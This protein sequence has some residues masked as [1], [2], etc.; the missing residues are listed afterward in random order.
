[1]KKFFGILFAIVILIL[2]FI[3]SVPK[4]K[5]FASSNLKEDI[6][7]YKAMATMEVGS[8]RLLYSYNENERLPMASTTKIITAIC[9]IENNED[10]DKIIEIPHEAQGVEGSSIYLRAGEHLSLR[11][12]LY[13]LMLQ[14]GNDSAVALA[15]ATS[16]TVD[17]FIE[18]A[19][20]FCERVGATNTHIVTPNGL[21][22]DNHYTTAKDLALISCYAMKNPIFREIVSTKKIEISNEFK[23]DPRVILNKNK[24]LKNLE[25]ATGIKTGYTK[26]AG[27]CLVASQKINDMEVVAVVLNCGPMFEECTSLLQNAHNEYS[28]VKLLDAYNHLGG[29]VAETGKEQ[30]KVNV[31]NKEGFIYPLTNL[32]KTEIRVSIS[33]PEKL[34]APVRKDQIIGQI[35]I[36]LSNQLLF[37]TKI[38]T[39]EEVRTITYIELIKKVIENMI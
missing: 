30:I 27:R 7:P 1:M 26:K 23:D 3:S 22:D 19:N 18:I 28:L 14:S 4:Q 38:Y 29:V 34:I 39:I 9:V 13:G 35:D 17:A 15:I 16:G 33:L 6:P 31:M 8:N 32:E 5:S 10:L 24:L 36:Y 2:F 25:G 37:S 12:L 20:K 11:E 21:H